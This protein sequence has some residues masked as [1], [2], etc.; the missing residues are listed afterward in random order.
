MLMP[1]DHL[2]T[3]PRDTPIGIQRVGMDVLLWVWQWA[4]PGVATE[5]WTLLDP[6]AASD[7]QKHPRKSLAGRN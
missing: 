4:G 7:S 2:P 1:L 3:G 5:T 6:L